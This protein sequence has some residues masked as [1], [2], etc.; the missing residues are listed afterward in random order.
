MKNMKTKIKGFSVC[1]LV[2]VAFALLTGCGGKVSEGYWVLTEVTEGKETVK[3]T[4]LEDYGL[5]NAYL[6]TDEDGD[7]YAVLFDVPVDFEIDTEDG[8]ME[9]FTGTVDY[10]ISGKKLTLSDSNL[11]MVF[12]KSKLDAP[13]KPEE[14]ALLYYTPELS[15]RAEEEGLT[16]FFAEADDDEEEDEDGE[17]DWDFGDDDEEDDSDGGS[18]AASPREYFEGDWYGWW[19]I[20]GR[21]DFWKQLDGQMFDI[22]CEVKMKDDTH[23]TITLWDTEMTYDEP[24]AKVDVEVANYASDENIGAL[25]SV[26]GTFLDGKIKEGDWYIDPGM[27]GFSDYMLISATYVDGDGVDAMDYAFH[28]KKWGADW[29]DFPTPPPSIDWYEDLV[30]NGEPMPDSVPE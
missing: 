14:L 29:D 9:F 7:G 12:E 6:V 27:L 20:D 21:T 5:D 1:A 13:E 11:T 15:K 10:K 25:T 18:P 28:L 2:C 4:D 19:S 17:D 8:T 3:D 24:I 22:L 30:D 23:G 26:K 16:D